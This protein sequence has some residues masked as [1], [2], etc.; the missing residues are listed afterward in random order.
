MID[1]LIGAINQLGY[2]YFFFIILVG[3]NLTPIPDPVYIMLAGSQATSP[4]VQYIPAFILTYS[5]M[6]LSLY[7]KF[8]IASLFSAQALALL[9]RPR[10]EKNV[11]KVERTIQE[12]GSHAIIASYFLP[13]MRH[14]MPFF[15]GASGMKH[16]HSFSFGFIWTLALF[17][18]GS[19]F[20]TTSSYTDVIEITL[21]FCAISL[22]IYAVQR[23][24]IRKKQQ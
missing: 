18:F 1:Q 20:N 10:W 8:L 16:R 4:S 23:R 13:G 6:M 19:F 7:L 24:K 17:I 2:G 9:K 3:A 22:I 21:A 5:G 14:V 15:L 12:Y 11:M